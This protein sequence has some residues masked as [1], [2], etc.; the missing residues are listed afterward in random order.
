SMLRDAAERGEPFVAELAVAK[1][2]TTE[3]DAIAALEPFAASGVPS[4]AALA[5]QLTVIIRPMLGAAETSA[6]ATSGGFWKKLRA[7]AQSLV[8][9]SPADGRTRASNEHDAILARAEQRA[10]QGDVTDARE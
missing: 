2:L 3:A 8:R 1:P 9:I 10:A 6:P 7:N 4:N 5:Q